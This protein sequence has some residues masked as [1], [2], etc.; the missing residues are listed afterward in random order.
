[1]DNINILKIK[2][3]SN[4]KGLILLKNNFEDAEAI[5]TIALADAP[6]PTP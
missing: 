6:K 5:V 2:E 4:M 1:M 3:V